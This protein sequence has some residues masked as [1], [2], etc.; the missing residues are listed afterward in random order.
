MLQRVLIVK[1]QGAQFGTNNRG[2]AILK[3]APYS[4]HECTVPTPPPFCLCC[5]HEMQLR[6]VS[7]PHTVVTA[8]SHGV[9]N[10]V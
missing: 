5:E 4:P 9:L 8:E 3:P 1:G 6:L 7:W 10:M 2:E